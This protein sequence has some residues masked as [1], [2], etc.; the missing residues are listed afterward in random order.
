[1]Q[2]GVGKGLYLLGTPLHHWLFQVIPIQGRI[3]WFAKVC[4]TIHGSRKEIFV[5]TDSSITWSSCKQNNAI[6][7]TS[8]RMSLYHTFSFG[9]LAKQS[10]NYLVISFPMWMKLGV[11]WYRLVK[12]SFSFYC[13]FFIFLLFRFMLY[14]FFSIFFSVKLEFLFC[15]VEWFCYRLR[16]TYYFVFQVRSFAYSLRLFYSG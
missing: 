8:Q 15:R 5:A 9:T 10:F 3:W 16:L 2:F 1:M 14:Y 7:E 12:R 13:V 4:E 6:T 11:R